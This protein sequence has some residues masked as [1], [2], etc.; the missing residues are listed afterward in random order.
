MYINTPLQQ[1]LDDLASSQST[2]GGGSASALSGAMGAGLASM[3]ARLTL[4]KADY[5]DVQQE[6]E[7]LIQQTE[8]LRTRFQ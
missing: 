3:V 1:Y 2:P 4:G 8:Q 6:I 5:A 7:S